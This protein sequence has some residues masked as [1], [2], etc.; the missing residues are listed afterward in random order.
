MQALIDYITKST[1]KREFAALVFGWWAGLGTYLM[2]RTPITQMAQDAAMQAWGALS[3]PV[4]TL[5]SLAFGAD[6]VAKQTNLAGPPIG[7]ETTV[8]TEITDTSATTTTT[9]VQTDPPTPEVKP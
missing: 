1:L 8:K 4:F 3:I 9:A 5:A 2:I 6:F 7:T